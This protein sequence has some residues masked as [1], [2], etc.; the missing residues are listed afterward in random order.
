MLCSVVV[1]NRIAR[2][3]LTAATAFASQTRH[4]HDGEQL[5]EQQ[6]QVRYEYK[7]D[8]VVLNVVD[9]FGIATDSGALAAAERV[10]VELEVARAVVAAAVERVRQRF[11]DRTRWVGA[12]RALGVDVI[13][14][15]Q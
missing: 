14:K 4:R 1:I 13:D 6:H 12:R 10:V 3:E 5:D 2:V 9:N 15:L 7:R 8:G 11:R